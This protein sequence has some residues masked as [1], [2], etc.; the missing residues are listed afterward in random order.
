VF[1][2]G[3]GLPAQRGARLGGRAAPARAGRNEKVTARKRAV[4]SKKADRV[5]KA[6]RVNAKRGGRPLVTIADCARR[7][8]G[9]NVYRGRIRRFDHPDRYIQLQQHVGGRVVARPARLPRRVGV[10]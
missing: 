9:T 3:P 7:P 6:W 10:R 4:T 1:V 5:S 2:A 8:P